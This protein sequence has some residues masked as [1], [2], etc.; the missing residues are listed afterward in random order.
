M[1]IREQLAA[2][3]HHIFGMVNL[4]CG[5]VGDQRRHEASVC[6]GRRIRID[7][8]KKVVTF[9]R[10][11]ARPGKQVMTGSGWRLVGKR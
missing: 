7:H 3:G 5:L 9:V 4:Y 11:V 10:H 8:G 1:I 6:R 2:L